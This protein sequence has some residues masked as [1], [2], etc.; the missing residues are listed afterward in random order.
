MF[1]WSHVYARICFMK[2]IIYD[3]C[4]AKMCV[5]IMEG[6]IRAPQWC[7]LHNYPIVLMIE[8][9]YK[10]MY[11]GSRTLSLSYRPGLL[12]GKSYHSYRCLPTSLHFHLHNVCVLVVLPSPPSIC[13]QLS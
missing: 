3:V 11:A 13:T 10:A 1:K 4:M 5:F 7:F 2:M 9:E 8:A 6:K 12:E